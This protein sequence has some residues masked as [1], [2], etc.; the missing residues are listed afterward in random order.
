MQ[1]VK[2]I[3]LNV[4]KEFPVPVQRLF[5]A[6]V[7]EGDLK[8]WWHPMGSRLQ[9]VRNDLNPGGELAYLFATEEGERSFTISGRYSEVREAELLVYSWNWEVPTDTIQNSSYQLTVRFTGTGGGSRLEVTQENFSDE[10][11]VQP[12][13]EGWEKALSDLQAYLT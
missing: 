13:R 9:E 10:A 6:W 7:Q 2:D 12:H 11:S 4:T 3:K 5:E 8:Q 1:A